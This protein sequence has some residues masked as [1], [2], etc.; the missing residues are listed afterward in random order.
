MTPDTRLRTLAL[1]ALALSAIAIPGPA[2]AAPSPMGGPPPGADTAIVPKGEELG[3]MPGG[4]PPPV[5]PMTILTFRPEN[6]FMKWN[7]VPWLVTDTISNAMSRKGYLQAGQYGNNSLLSALWRQ[8]EA[9]WYVIGGAHYE[10]ARK[11]EDGDGDEVNFGY[12]RNGQFL[13]LGM[14]PKPFID[15]KIAFIR[16][17]IRNDRQPHFMMD[18][19]LTTRTIFRFESRLGK[20]DG[21]RTVNVSAKN[22]RLKRRAG[23]F[24]LREL[25]EIA[26]RVRQAVDRNI[27]DVDVNAN[28]GFAD[29]HFARFGATYTY[30]TMTGKRYL[31]LP[32]GDDHNAYKMPQVEQHDVRLYGGYEFKPASNQRLDLGLAWEWNRADPVER[33]HVFS[34]T[35]S[36]NMLWKRFY[37]KRVDKPVENDAWSAKARYSFAFDDGRKNAHLEAESLARIGSNNERFSAVPGPGGKSNV[38]NPFIKPERHN[39]VELGFDMAGQGW[40]G[41]MTPKFDDFAHSWSLEGAVYY[42]KVTDLIVYD[43]ARGQSGLTPGL[44][45]GD[46]VIRNV[47]GSFAGAKLA[48]RHNLTNNF[49]AYA[50]TEYR[51]GQN[52]TDDRPM[53]RVAPWTTVVGA[54][55]MNYFRNGTWSVGTQA[56]FVA[57]QTRLDDS[58]KTGLGDDDPIAAKGETVVDLHGAIQFRNR[59]GISFGVDNLFNQKYAEFMPG[60][61]VDA[62]GAPT[63]Y[64]PGRTFW[65]KAHVNF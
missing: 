21:T 63:V 55:Y 10:K 29:R 56:R 41:Y 31:V 17:D 3:S 37:G 62:I 11:Y 35:P 50:S 15:S 30:D 38:G 9:N 12:D 8:R 6:Q 7:D 32:K 44:T 47:D 16:D 36:P 26:P 19:K 58:V 5:T 51:Y 64:A 53:Y 13:A 33:D 45:T 52:E 28:F 25:P 22:A 14:V 27:T 1:G 65:A 34:K 57:E 20:P 49:A 46:T 48:Y 24:Y 54:D 43:R 23:N 18:P 4:L 60:L 42:D 39:R 61:H 40:G 59:L 2:A